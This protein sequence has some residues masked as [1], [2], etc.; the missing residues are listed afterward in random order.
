MHAPGQ[1]NPTW[2][3]AGRVRACGS[4]R[5]ARGVVESRDPMQRLPLITAGQRK[6][7]AG[8]GTSFPGCQPAGQGVFRIYVDIRGEH[9]RLG[10]RSN[11]KKGTCT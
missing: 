8:N 1:V 2:A 10:A 4:T 11:A 5:C 9:L 7:N 3:G 6:E